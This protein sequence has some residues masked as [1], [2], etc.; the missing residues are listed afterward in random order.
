M[1]LLLSIPEALKGPS[2][3]VH[4]AAKGIFW[5]PDRVVFLL[6]LVLNCSAAGSDEP[7]LLFPLCHLEASSSAFPVMA[8]LC[9]QQEPV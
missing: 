4:N 5:L 9:Q 7:A 3:A 8:L 6:L 2:S 1:L